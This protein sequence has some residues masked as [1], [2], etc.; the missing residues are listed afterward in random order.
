MSVLFHFAPLA[1]PRSLAPSPFGRGWI[2]P[3]DNS[4]NTYPAV[5]SAQDAKAVVS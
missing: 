3:R 2:L 4:F 1:T 5:F